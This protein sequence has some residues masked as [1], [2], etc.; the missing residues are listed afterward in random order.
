M[1]KTRRS[2]AYWLG[3]ASYH[4]NDNPIYNPGYRKHSKRWIDWDQG[5]RDAYAKDFWKALCG[6]SEVERVVRRAGRI[7]ITSAGNT[8]SS[9]R[10]WGVGVVTEG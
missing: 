2:T 5:W 1:K 9:I 10:D 8:W 7:V 4:D 3:Y 6:H